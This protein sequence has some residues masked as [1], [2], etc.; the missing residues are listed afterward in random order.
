[1][2]PQLKKG[3]KKHEV[4][5]FVLEELY[6]INDGAKRALWNAGCIPS[7]VQSQG[8]RRIHPAF[9][10]DGQGRYADSD[11]TPG[12][13]DPTPEPEAHRA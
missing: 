5:I 1:M 10:V 2:F 9:S 6:A 13:P 12:I 11:L 8:D 3:T 4:K 7:R